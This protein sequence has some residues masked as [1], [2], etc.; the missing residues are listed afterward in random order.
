LTA[1]IRSSRVQQEAI[2]ERLL[3]VFVSD[4]FFLVWVPA[5]DP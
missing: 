1:K 5:I 3:G 4:A 2:S